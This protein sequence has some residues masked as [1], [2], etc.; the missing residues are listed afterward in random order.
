MRKY[1][2]LLFI[3]TTSLFTAVVMTYSYEWSDYRILLKGLMNPNKVWFFGNSVIRHSSKCDEDHRSIAQ[4]FSSK[5]QDTVVDMSRGGMTIDRMLDITEIL[6]KLGAKPKA[7]YFQIAL[8]EDFSK[9]LNKQS[10]LNDYFFTNL[11]IIKSKLNFEF[12]RN[13]EKTVFNDKFYGSYAEFSKSYFITEKKQTT[14]P[15]GVGVD[16]EFIAFMYWRNFFDKNLSKSLTLSH[17]LLKLKQSDLNAVFWISPVDYDDM[18]LLHG[19][20]KMNEI[21]AY[22]NNVLDSLKDLNVLDI[23]FALPAS[24]FADRWCACGHLNEHGR[25]F[26]ATQLNAIKW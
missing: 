21:Y 3:L 14:C 15:E 26:V 22:K 9:T 11:N 10:G 7:V 17:R 8:G 19:D 1:L 4:I 25:N 6:S 18:R 2:L 5:K 13:I 16:K 23:A 24:S 12:E 20:E